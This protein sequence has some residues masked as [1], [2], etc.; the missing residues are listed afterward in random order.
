VV[1]GGVALPRDAAFDGEAFGG[2][3]WHPGIRATTH[4]GA[5]R[6]SPA[7]RGGARVQAGK[8]KVGQPKPQR[9]DVHG[10]VGAQA[11]NAFATLTEEAECLRFEVFAT[12]FLASQT[13]EPGDIPVDLVDALLLWHVGRH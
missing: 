5:S 1:A 3:E 11:S 7:D 13:V 8:A 10:L 9:R 2:V 4:A 12:L 6:T